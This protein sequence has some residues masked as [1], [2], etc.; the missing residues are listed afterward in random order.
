MNEEDPKTDIE[1]KKNPVA[2][3]AVALVGLACGAYLANPGAGFIE[4]IPDNLP[5]IGNLDEAGAVA[6]LISCLAYFGLDVGALF[7]R[8]GK[9]EDEKTAKGK[10]ID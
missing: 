10:V 1:K 8:G 5:L 6:V 9:K 7:G 2:S 3:V 4:L